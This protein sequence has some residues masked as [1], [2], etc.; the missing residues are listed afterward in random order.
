MFA[1]ADMMTW[2]EVGAALARKAARLSEAGD[3]DA[4]KTVLAARIFAAEVGQL[5]CRRGMHVC[6]GTGGLAGGAVA[7]FLSEL[8]CEDLMQSCRGVYRDMDRAADILFGR[9]S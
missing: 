7:D 4:E 1:L 9:A 2:V 8:A 5:I 3:A 6:L